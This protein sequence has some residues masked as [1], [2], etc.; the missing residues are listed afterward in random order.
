MICNTPK[1]EFLESYKF[2]ITVYEL[3]FIILKWKNNNT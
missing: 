3:Q 2:E 1:E